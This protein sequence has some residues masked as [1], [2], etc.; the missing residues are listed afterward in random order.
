MS[1][2]LASI[3]RFKDHKVFLRY[4]D[5]AE[6]EIEDEELVEVEEEFYQFCLANLSEAQSEVKKGNSSTYEYSFFIISDDHHQFG[7]T[8]T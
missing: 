6:D 7:C 3:I 1:F 4:N 2:N 8:T 5:H